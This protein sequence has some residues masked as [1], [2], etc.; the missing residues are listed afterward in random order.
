M[1]QRAVI[2][3]PLSKLTSAWRALHHAE[4]QLLCLAS[5]EETTLRS[6]ALR[7]RLAS[8]PD[9]VNNSLGTQLAAHAGDAPAERA[10]LVAATED[11]HRQEDD[12]F[13]RE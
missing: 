11:L 8:D 3:I 6:P 1:P 13:E 4:T 12:D 2:A 7:L 5:P 10:L 9:P